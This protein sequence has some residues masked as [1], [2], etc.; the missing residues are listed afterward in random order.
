MGRMRCENL[1]KLTGNKKS[2]SKTRKHTFMGEN[3]GSCRNLAWSDPEHRLL[4]EVRVNESV[5]RLTVRLGQLS[6][7]P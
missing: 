4:H 6:L 3:Y 5:V 1:A 7:S 2:G